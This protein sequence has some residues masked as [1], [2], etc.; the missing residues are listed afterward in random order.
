LRI[1]SKIL[2]GLT[3]GLALL[4]LQATGQAARGLVSAKLRLLAARAVKKTAWEP[5]RRYA[6]ATRNP[7]QR[8]KAYFVLGY[9]EYEADEYELAGE[10][11]R[12]AAEM[13]F[14]LADMARYY[15]GNAALQAGHADRAVEAVEGFSARYAKSSLRLEALAV[16]AQALLKSGQPAR[17]IQEL[18]AEPLVRRRPALTILLAQ[19][20]LEAKRF[21]DAARVYQDVYYAYPTSP[22]ADTAQDALRGLKSQLGPKFPSVAEEIQTAHAETLYRSLR[23][24]DAL[25]EYDMLLQAHVDSPLALRWKLGRAR[26]L[27][28][29]GQT[30]AAIEALSVPI[31]RNPEF[32][33]QRLAMLTD[34][35]RRRDD[36]SAVLRTLDELRQRHPQ[37]PFY[38]SALET[39]GNYFLRKGDWSGAA[40]YYRPLAE[41]FPQSEFAPTAHW[42]AAWAHYLAR[43]GDKAEQA[44]VEHITRY[45]DSRMVPAA[46]YWL[47]RLAEGR[48]ASGEAR[49]LYE[50]LGNR[51]PHSY[52]SLLAEKRLR[53][54]TRKKAKG[55]K[56]TKA[57]ASDRVA[58]LARLI[59]PVR[60]LRLEPCA[61][62]ESSEALRPF[63]TLRALKLDDLAEQYLTAVASE[64]TEEPELLLALCRYER[65]QK[66][67]A[68]ALLRV[69]GMLPDYTE[70]DFDLLPKEIWELLYPQTY[71]T[72][73]SRQARAHGL[74]ARLIMGMIRQE[75]AF[76]PRATSRAGARG[77]MQ[78]RPTTASSSRSG[79]RRRA[80]AQRLYDPTYNLRVGCRY[81]QRLR[82]DFGGSVEQALAAYHAGPTRVRSWLEG[83]QF[84][85]PAE[86]LESI[87][88]GSTRLYV[89][90]VLRDAGVYHQLMSGSARFAQC[91]SGAQAEKKAVRQ[92]SG[93]P[94]PGP[95]MASPPQAP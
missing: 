1:R 60:P 46:L 64:R 72:L 61:R 29:L 66:N 91:P 15:W 52:Y 5:L 83:H 18:T 57:V 75:S 84:L 17:A 22:Q 89:E 54:L 48:W 79:R 58:E 67:T 59:P 92:T 87:P 37:S 40:R 32:D 56:Q 10:D 68:R 77:L 41:A 86:F 39:A 26:C 78:I 88:I 3:L 90:R 42:R 28:R 31:K 47:G 69:V 19:A 44:F 55:A 85:E 70:Y 81:L 80:V 30:R 94:R 13:A 53:V 20:Y 12:R 51:F 25:G 45:P 82:K 23:L 8:G 38:A 11:L 65:E 73:V 9:R 74:D 76:N 7:Q 36:D 62:E 21:Q 24:T 49:S 43:E 6:E 14:S 95:S 27:V 71:R 16:L 2:L 4:P 50:L 63:Q 35:Y 33:A 93:T 34:A